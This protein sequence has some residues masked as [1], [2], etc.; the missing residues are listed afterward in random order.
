MLEDDHLARIGGDE[1]YQTV[2]GSS[3]DR[4]RVRRSRLSRYEAEVTIQMSAEAAFD[5][6]TDAGRY[7]QWQI[8]V[9]RAFE[10][11]APVDKAGT[12]LKVDYGS[13]MTRNVAVT[14]SERPHRYVVTETGMRSRNQTAV[15]FTPL[16]ADQTRVSLTHDLEV[17]MGLL[18]G[19]LERVTRANTTKQAAKEL[20]RFAK[21]AG[22]PMAKAEA[23]TLYTVDAHAG[24]RL[25]KVIEVEG[26]I[27]HIALFPGSSGQRPTDLGMFLDGKSLLVDPLTLQPLRPPLKRTA[28]TVVVG[29]PLLAM[30]G[31]VG[32]PHLAVTVGAFTDALP[33][34][35]GHFPVF[36]QELAE[37][38]SWREGHGPV[39]GRD[40]DAT[41]TPL[42]SA[43]V[44]NG[45]SVA[46]LLHVERNG[47]HLRQYANR[48]E[49]PP[50]VVDPWQLR[51]DRFDAP[52]FSIGH[53]PL[54]RPAFDAMNPAFIRLAMRSTDELE[55]YRM[56]QE[57]G[58][59]YF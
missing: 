45:Y 16:G 39:L 33:E 40:L 50:V 10:A 47:V 7:P 42:I 2:P 22:R 25:V 29:Q 56:W 12:T 49:A 57:G 41:I 34:A 28:S 18:S 5:L 27:V 8:A 37:V 36:T 31:G 48:W 6:W 24:Y 53:V 19:L 59:G 21:I 30:D 43:L 35:A 38:S 11:T 44:D 52:H 32:V 26:D 54:S 23:G 3:Y 58:G 51:L 46:K 55:G 1:S 20:E 14:E 17:Q 13:R 4:D 9:L 15:T